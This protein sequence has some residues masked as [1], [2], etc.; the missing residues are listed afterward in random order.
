[1]HKGAVNSSL[2]GNAPEE[3]VRGEHAARPQ[4]RW[5]RNFRFSHRGIDFPT[6]RSAL[7]RCCEP[8]PLPARLRFRCQSIPADCSSLSARHYPVP[9]S[10]GHSACNGGQESELVFCLSSSVPGTAGQAALRRTLIHR[11]RDAVAGRRAGRQAQSEP[12]PEWRASILERGDAGVCAVSHDGSAGGGQADRPHEMVQENWDALLAFA[13]RFLLGR[14]ALQQF[15][16]F[17]GICR[18]ERFR[19]DA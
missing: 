3:A 12:Q 4:G 19:Q 17:P 8:A 7:S 5:A 10:P 11:A 6:T 9:P 14:T 18:Q 13:D 15:D 16:Q 2:G 1:M